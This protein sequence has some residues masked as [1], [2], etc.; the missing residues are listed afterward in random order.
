MNDE[1]PTTSEGPENS[2]SSP[3]DRHV[4]KGRTVDPDGDLSPDFQVTG[5]GGP[6]GGEREHAPAPDPDGFTMPLSRRQKEMRMIMT[7]FFEAG[8]I[9][10]DVLGSRVNLDD[11]EVTILGEVWGNFTGRFIEITE[12]GK[13]MDGMKAAG[14]SIGVTKQK[15]SEYKQIKQRE[16]EQNR[17][18]GNGSDR[19]D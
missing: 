9:T 18:D 1:S 16:N 12:A 11:E 7:G 13:W 19:T 4:E 17:Q 14:A 5:T 3:I 15:L 8:Q 2:Q 10:A 6:E